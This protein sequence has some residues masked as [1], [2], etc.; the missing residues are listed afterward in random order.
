MEEVVGATEVGSMMIK[1]NSFPMCDRE[2]YFSVHLQHCTLK[3][4]AHFD[5]T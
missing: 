4:F 1:E 2:Y 5:V 3:F